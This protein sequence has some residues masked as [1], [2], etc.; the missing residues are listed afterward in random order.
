MTPPRGCARRWRAGPSPPTSASI[1]RRPAC[2]SGILLPIM[3]LA[4]LQRS[5][6]PPIALVG[7]GTGL[8]GDPERQEPGAPAAHPR[9]GRGERRRHPRAARAVPRLR[10]PGNAARIVNNA[11][12]L[13]ADRPARLPARRRQA[14]H[15]QL[16]ARE[17]SV[18][19]RLES[20]D[21]ISF[22]E[23]SYMLLQALRLP[24]ALRPPRRAR[25]RWAAATSGAT[26]PPAPT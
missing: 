1:R 18:K 5:G 15:R 2:T 4:R 24:G 26:S 11:D 19:R 20:E 23:F 3:A 6:H 14:L 9:A 13:G 7:G 16:H 21:G 17:G 22:T 8:I 25:C 12:W 10:R